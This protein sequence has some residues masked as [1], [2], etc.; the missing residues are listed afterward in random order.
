MFE[1]G[2]ESQLLKAILNGNK[3]IEGRLGK[4]KYLKIRVGDIL[5]FRE[6]VYKDGKLTKSISTATTATV[7]QLLYFESFEEMLNSIDFQATVPEAS[8]INEALL[9]YKKYY[10]EEDEEEYGVVA[11]SF[12]LN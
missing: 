3:T 4:P 11:I 1:I 8:T 5:S 6:D 10:S 2:V 7:T 12:Q 9:R